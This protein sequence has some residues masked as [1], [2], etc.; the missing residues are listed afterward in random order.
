MHVTCQYFIHT[1]NSVAIP[2]LSIH[3]HYH[4]AIHRIEDSLLHLLFN[5]RC[6]H[7]GSFE[8]NIPSFGIHMVTRSRLAIM[9]L[10]LRS[11]E[12]SLP[13]LRQLLS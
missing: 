10:Q 13:Q 7:Q 12:E 8:R 3:M 2:G 4:L 5:Q 6:E 9:T 1:Y 11:I